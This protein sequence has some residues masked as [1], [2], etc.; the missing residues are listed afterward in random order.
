M[1]TLRQDIDARLE[2]LEAEKNALLAKKASLE[3]E[4]NGLLDK[5][6]SEVKSF[7]A[8]IAAHFSWVHIDD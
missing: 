2:A 4:A 1:S 7:F 8:R 6:E 3:A 5:E